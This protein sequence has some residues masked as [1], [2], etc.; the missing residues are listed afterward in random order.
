MYA[1][2]IP[3]YGYAPVTTAPANGSAPPYG[4]VPPSTG[5]PYAPPTPMSAR[6]SGPSG[7]SSQPKPKTDAQKLHSFLAECLAM[8]TL[9]GFKYFELYLRGR[10]ELLIRVYN[11][12]DKHAKSAVWGRLPSSAG[13]ARMQSRNLLALK[14]QQRLAW[15]STDALPPAS[16][17]DREL[18]RDPTKTAFLLAGY[19][20]Y[21]CPFVWLRTNHAKFRNTRPADA[22]GTNEDV[23]LKLDTVAKWKSVDSIHASDVVAEVI[24]LAV[25]PPPMNPYAINHALYDS[26]PL[27]ESVVCAG[28]MV[29]FLG[30]VYASSAPYAHLVL[31]DIERLFARVWAETADLAAV[32]PTLGGGSASPRRGSINLLPT[33]AGAAAAMDSVVETI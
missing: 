3:A 29:D 8:G 24:S 14:T 15:Q 33:S 1:P 22:S 17:C 25:T 11:D 7:A 10:E 9:K 16:P 2:P 20:K 32:D 4:G 12:A 19:A 18:E 6:P 26:L 28:A 27:E 31:A 21:K 23:P 30:K 5:N 13:L